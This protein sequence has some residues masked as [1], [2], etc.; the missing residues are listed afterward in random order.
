VNRFLAKLGLHVLGVLAGWDRL[1]FRGTILRLA[2]S[3]GLQGFLNQHRILRQ[4]FAAFSTRVTDGIRSAAVALAS[5][6]GRPFVYLAS[7]SIDKEQTVR[8]I[9]QRD[10][11]TEGLIC[12]LACQ[13]SGSSYRI[14]TNP[15]THRPEFAKIFPRTQH[16]YWYFVDP[17]FGYMHVRV[18]TWFPFAVQVYIN[19]RHWLARQLDE[20]GLRYAMRD[21][22]FPWIEDFRKAQRLADRQLALR[23]ETELASVLSSACPPLMEFTKRYGLSYYWSLWQSELATDIV[24]DS[25]RTVAGI[26]SKLRNHAM[27]CFSPSDVLRFLGQ[28]VNGNWAGQ[29]MSDIKGRPDTLRIKHRVGHNSVKLYAKEAKILRTETTIHSPE[30]LKVFRRKQG[31]SNGPKSWRQMRCGIA[32]MRRRADLSRQ[33]NDRYQNALADADTSAQLGEIL[34]PFTRRTTWRGRKVRGLRPWDGT[35]VALL[36]AVNNPAHHLAGLQNRDV[37]DALYPESAKDPAERRRRS[38]RVSRLLRLLRAHGLIGK[39]GKTRRYRV[40]AKGTEVITAVLKAQSLSL[41]TLKETA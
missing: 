34:Q 38:G 32:D 22:C 14:V 21:N 30:E 12:V 29:V 28:K 19:G 33:A 11:V 3:T 24:L 41:N 31:D 18:Q 35:D 10:E 13:E 4:D 15:E 7:P 37:Q 8:R 23:W 1:L 16:L 2:Y 5:D 40:T 17:V 25:P 36:R 6:L 9:A 26:E 39:I 27:V 20:A